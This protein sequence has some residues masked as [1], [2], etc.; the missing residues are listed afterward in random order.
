MSEKSHLER[1]AIR[2]KARELDRETSLK[3][4]DNSIWGAVSMCSPDGIPHNEAS[5]RVILCRK[6][7]FDSVCGF[8]LIQNEALCRG[9]DKFTTKEFLARS[10]FY[11]KFMT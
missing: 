4:V 11:D 3:I 1:T 5:R 9:Y 6:R 10:K 8:L 2:L 7:L